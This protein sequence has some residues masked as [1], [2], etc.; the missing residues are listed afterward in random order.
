MRVL[1]PIRHAPLYQWLAETLREDI[2][3]GVHQPGDVLPTEHELMRS[4]NLSTTTVRRAVRDLVLEGLIYR[5]AGK[6]TFVKR[7]RVEEHLSR[8]TSY[9][10]EMHSR[11]IVPSFKLVCARQ[12]IP[13]SEVNRA[14]N[15]PSE[16]QAFYIERVLLGN[17]APIALARG[18]WRS[19]TGEHQ[20]QHDLNRIALYKVV[21]RVLHIPLVE[22]DESISAAGDDY[23]LYPRASCQLEGL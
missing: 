21:E 23:I 6:G 22:A 4:Y 2:S 5:K 1:D 13:P 7:T 14:L 3:Q 11:G 20:A 15:L 19:E 16:Q 8:L 18:Y 9:A 10:E 17:G 12:C